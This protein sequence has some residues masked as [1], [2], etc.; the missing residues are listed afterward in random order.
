MTF[1]L[2]SASRLPKVPNDDD[3]DD[4]HDNDSNDTATV[5]VEVIYLNLKHL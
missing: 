4:D 3:D 5:A 1:S 2:L